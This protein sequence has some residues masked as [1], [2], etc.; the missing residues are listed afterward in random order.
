MK[1]KAL[2]VLWYFHQWEAMVQ[3]GTVAL[4]LMSKIDASGVML[5]NMRTVVNN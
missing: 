2:W 1:S 5:K 4:S 3:V